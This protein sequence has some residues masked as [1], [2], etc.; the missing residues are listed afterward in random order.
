MVRRLVREL[1][2]GGTR[3]QKG[4]M[5]DTAVGAHVCDFIGE[6]APLLEAGLSIPRNISTRNIRIAGNTPSSNKLAA[7]FHRIAHTQRTHKAVSSANN[8]SSEVR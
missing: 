2:V 5:G 8:V 1:D 6:G 3:A 7:S 4:P